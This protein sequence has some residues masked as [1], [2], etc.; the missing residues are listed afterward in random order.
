MYEEYNHIVRSEAATIAA[1]IYE[2]HDLQPELLI[3]LYDTISY[4]VTEDTEFIVRQRALQFWKNVI[5]SHL[6]AQ[7][8]IDGAFPEVTFSKETRKIVILN[9]MEVKK[10]LVK[11]LHQLSETGCLSALKMALEDSDREVRKVVKDIV[12]DFYD[13]LKKYEVNVIDLETPNSANALFQIH[14][15]KENEVNCKFRGRNIIFP[16]IFLDYVTDYFKPNR[17][18]S[19]TSQQPLIAKILNEIL[20][21]DPHLG[22]S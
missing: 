16:E 12:N 22:Y 13:F 21:G 2:H 1:I 7:G 5:N 4:T 14:D 17:N 3:K 9:N 10:R 6:S 18:T 8:M 15:L 11:I 19:E 20:C